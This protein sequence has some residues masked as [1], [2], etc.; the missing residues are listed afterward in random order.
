MEAKD[1][2]PILGID[3]LHF[4]VGS[5]KHTSTFLCQ[6]FGFSERA[7]KG[8]ETGERKSASRLLTQ[9]DIRFVITCGLGSD[10]DIVRHVAK[11]GDGVKDIALRVPNARAAYKIA[12]ERSAIHIK[13]P[14][15]LKDKDGEIVRAIIGT[16]GDT[17]HSLIERSDHH[18]HFFPGFESVE[19]REQENVGLLSIDHIVGNVELGQMN[20]YADYYAR[21]MGFT[22]L[23]TFDDKQISTKFSALMSKVMWNGSKI[24]FPINEPAAGKRKSQVEEYLDFYG[25]PGVQHIAME[26][27]DIVQTVTKLR[28]RGVKFLKIP[29]AYYDDLRE[30]FADIPDV[31]VDA[32]QDLGVLADRDEEGYLL[33]IFTKP[34]VDRPTLFF[35]IIERHGSR[36]F[37][38]GNF[39][40]L[41]VAL[42]REQDRRGNL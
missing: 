18:E 15:V 41:F 16:Y 9:G 36:G 42:E 30:R 28:A 4:L 14:E 37:G 20:R 33:Q 19:S 6:N 17:V 22:N 11:H 25:G 2:F 8:L 24:K 27:E 21:V 7:Y 40:A 26:S 32:L 29:K 35:E 38:E 34:I 12:M 5:S 1:T 13:A 23:I 31:N 10:S 39:K 3:H